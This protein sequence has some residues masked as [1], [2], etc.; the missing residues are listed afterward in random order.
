[1]QFDPSSLNFDSTPLFASASFYEFEPHNEHTFLGERQRISEKRQLTDADFFFIVEDEPQPE[2][3]FNFTEDK[4]HEEEAPLLPL[5][6]VKEDTQDDSS[7]FVSSNGSDS[8][9]REF[10]ENLNDIVDDLVGAKQSLLGLDSSLRVRAS[11]AKGCVR[12]R[13]R[14]TSKQMLVLEAEYARNPWWSRS[15]VA[16][17]SKMLQLSEAQVYKWNWDKRK[18]LMSEEQKVNEMFGSVDAYKSI[19]SHI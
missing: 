10:R 15:L 11:K 6:P 14:K 3:S 4:I 5:S 9:V 2:R 1:M 12:R 7:A 19:A 17:L 13:R 18:K 16:N 8:P